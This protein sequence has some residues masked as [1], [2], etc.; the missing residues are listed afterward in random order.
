M[1]D[2][3]MFLGEKLTRRQATKALRSVIKRDLH[4]DRTPLFYANTAAADKA[5]AGAASEHDA[6]FKLRHFCFSEDADGALLELLFDEYFPING[7]SL[8]QHIVRHANFPAHRLAKLYGSKDK[9]VMA[10]LIRNPNTDGK[11]L[12]R[13]L[14]NRSEDV[15][16]NFAFREN[17]DEDMIQSL[18]NFRTDGPLQC[19]AD[20]TNDAQLLERILNEDP[21][22]D[23]KEEIAG[24]EQCTE[25]LLN[26]LSYT[27]EI[28]NDA[29]GGLAAELAQL[30]RA[31]VLRK[32]AM[33]SNSKIEA[34]NRIIKGTSNPEILAKAV[35]HKNFPMSEAETIISS[36]PS[37]ICRELKLWAKVKVA[38]AQKN[39]E[40]NIRSVAVDTGHFI[41]AEVAN[42]QKY[43][44]D[45][46]GWFQEKIRVPKG[47]HSILIFLLECW[48]D[49][50]VKELELN[51]AEDTDFVL[52][53]PS[54]I[55]DDYQSFLDDTHHPRSGVG[56]DGLLFDTGGDSFGFD[57]GVVI[58]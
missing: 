34:L 22:N 3:V 16:R 33:N 44:Y 5:R 15:K 43:K 6:A 27:K 40:K 9:E 32:V 42:L 45:P 18:F 4:P 12:K 19:L 14:K 2:Q 56:F 55:L 51:L 41:F 26:R 28:R 31:R 20:F 37:K 24:N 50:C 48:D 49:P 38:M 21:S 25:I 57:V 17:L 23:V 29:G 53:D 35:L 8:L 36:N 7:H 54:Y 58:S 10:G 47:H 11:E 46:E 39:S 30:A 13:L 52:S 1:N